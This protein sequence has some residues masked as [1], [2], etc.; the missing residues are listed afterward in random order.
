MPLTAVL[1]RSSQ[2]DVFD[3]IVPTVD[4]VLDGINATILTYVG[5]PFLPWPTQCYELAVRPLCIRVDR[6]HFVAPHAG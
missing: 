6:R 5:L 2:A 4:A 3:A 1:E